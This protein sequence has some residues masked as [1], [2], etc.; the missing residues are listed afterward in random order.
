[1]N[2]EAEFKTVDLIMQSSAKTRGVDAFALALIKAER[3]IRKLFTHLIYQFP[4]FGA[5]N[6]RTLRET[7][8]A[9]RR[10][11]FAGFVNGF[12]A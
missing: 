3:Q 2:Y 9:N 7:L 1:M 12:D 8:A 4:C 11:Y 6:V 5:S 10:V